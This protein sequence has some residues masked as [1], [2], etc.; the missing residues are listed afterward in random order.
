MLKRICFL[1]LSLVVYV[2]LKVTY[3]IINISFKL[4]V[5]VVQV[6]LVYTCKKLY[7]LKYNLDHLH[8]FV[9]YLVRVGHTS[10]DRKGLKLSST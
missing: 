7:V 10:I 1:S 3:H 4:M 2:R 8:V 5:S 6:K 9:L